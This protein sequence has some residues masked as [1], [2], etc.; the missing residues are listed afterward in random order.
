MADEGARD[1]RFG[2][3]VSPEATRIDETLAVARIADEAGLDLLGVQDH[4]YQRRFLDAWTLIATLLART[5]RVHV[6]PDVAN[7]P[8]RPPA[9][10]A[11]TAASLDA[12]SGGRVELGL[13]AGAFWPAIAAMGGPDRSRREAAAAL[14]EAVDIIRLLWS[15]ERSVR[16]DGDH[17]RVSGVH[18]GPPPAHDI[19][20]W[21]GVGG[22]RMLALVGRAADGW[23]PSNTYIP[24]ERLPAMQERIDRAAREAGRDPA[25]IRRIYNVMGTVTTGPATG[26]FAGPVD[27]WAATLT[28]LVAD[29]G[30]DAFV[31]GPEQDDVT[32]AKRFAHEVVPAAREALAARRGASTQDGPVVRDNTAEH[33]YEILVAG[34]VAAFT[35]Y[36]LADGLVEFFHTQTARQYRGRGLARQLVAETLAD[37]RAH[38]RLIRPICPYVRGFVARHAEYVDLVPAAERAQFGLA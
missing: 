5:E 27:H 19:G 38:G 16:Y 3:F 24:P 32:Q 28:E 36:R 34:H 21:L 15:Q 25:G 29:Y 18:P 12:L 4:P 1:V 13:G 33:R 31:F 37:V 11:K 10:L 9:I 14:T 23:V 2:F 8:L 22:P 20:L 17:Y 26:P 7:L 30:M 6:F 35:E